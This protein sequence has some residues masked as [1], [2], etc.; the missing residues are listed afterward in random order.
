MKTF[1][2]FFGRRHGFD[3]WSGK[4]PWRRKWQIFLPGETRR[5]MSPVCYS[6]KESQRVRHNLATEQQREDIN[7][8]STKG[9]IEIARRCFKKYHS[10]LLIIKESERKGIYR[11]LSIKL[12]TF[13]N[14][15]KKATRERK[16]GCSLLRWQE[17]RLA[18]LRK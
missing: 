13:K 17:C 6:H 8:Q 14:E 18:L 12:E 3:P 4:N 2:F 16:D 10:T 1:F 15:S 5:E 11:F 9:A 7:Q